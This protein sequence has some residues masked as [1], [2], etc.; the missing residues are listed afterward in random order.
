[1]W[2]EIE[3]PSA[4]IINEKSQSLETPKHY[5]S[6]K[7]IDLPKTNRAPE[8]PDMIKQ[9]KVKQPSKQKIIPNPRKN[10]KLKKQI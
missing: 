3:K 9:Q 7:P 4:S 10:P 2:Q 1:M 8:L 6:I 5:E